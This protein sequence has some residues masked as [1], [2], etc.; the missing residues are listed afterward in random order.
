VSE[1][2]SVASVDPAA[3]LDPPRSLPF[4]FDAS[5][6][7]Y[8][9]IWIVNLLLTIVTLGIYS[10][11][12][13]VRRLRYFYG[14]T[15]LDGTAFEYHG[16][17]VAILK[18]RLIAVGVYGLFYILTQ[19]Q[20]LAAIGFLPLFMFGVPWIIMKSRRF[21]MHMTS[22]RGIRFGFDGGY[23]GALKAYIGWPLLA[24]I[25]A[26]L[27]GGRMIWEQV[28]YL[29]GHA[30]Y[31]TEPARFTTGP[32]PFNRCFLVAM[33]L[34][35]LLV[36]V[37]AV[38]FELLARTVRAE[39]DPENPLAHLLRPSVA[40]VVLVLFLAGFAIAAYYQKSRLNASFGGLAIGPH[41]VESRLETGPLF[42]IYLSNFVL[43]VLTLGLYSPWAKVRQMKYQMTSLAV[44]AR[45]DLDQ[46]AAAVGD[47]TDAIGEE[48]GDFFDLDFGL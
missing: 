47:G 3:S 10:A 11:W 14:N 17:P 24:A 7:E 5:G 48:I 42:V 15:R 37:F 43:I 20:P 46:F 45:G 40:G 26:Y 13:K 32:G 34:S 16:R 2:E 9:R 33:G 12:A 4:A 31:G 36:V 38:A 6:G 25:T 21:Q 35:S 8:F 41:R 27:L 18:G 29:L 44:V 39:A 1:A 28:R 30:R 23:R 19:L 22:Y